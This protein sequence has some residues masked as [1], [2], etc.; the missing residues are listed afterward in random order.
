V[1]GI[2][3]VTAKII[4]ELGLRAESIPHTVPGQAEGQTESCI[5]QT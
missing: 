3:Y 4:R 5:D 1:S 2:Q